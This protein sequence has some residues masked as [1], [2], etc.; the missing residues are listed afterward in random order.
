M[1]KTAAG[2]KHEHPNYMGIFWAL[3]VLTVAEV[4]AAWPAAGPSYPQFLK[5][6]LLVIMAVTKAA[7]VGAYFMHLRFE[8]R[9]LAMIAITPMLLCVF[10]LFM[11]MPD[12]M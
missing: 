10:L 7:L 8:K 3:L 9:T 6:A 1:G 11:L 12:F 4:G 2:E 5:G